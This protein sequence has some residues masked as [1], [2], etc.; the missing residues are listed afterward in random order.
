MGAERRRVMIAGLL[1]CVGLVAAGVSPVAAQETGDEVDVSTLYETETIDGNQQVRDIIRTENG[2]LIALVIT[3][4]GRETLV[5]GLDGSGAV[6][7]EETVPGRLESLTR[8][9][10]DAYAAAG[11]RGGTAILTR[12]NEDGWIEWTERY[13][14]DERDIGFDA[15]SAPHGDTYLLASTDSFENDTEYNSSNLWAVRVDDEGEIR[16]DRLIEYEQSAAF[17]QGERL[18][19]GSL[20][21]AIQTGRSV[22]GDDSDGESGVAA[23]RLAP[24]GDTEWRTTIPDIDEPSRSERV[25]DVAPAHDNGVVLAGGTNSGNADEDN[26]DAWAAQLGAD[27]DVVWQR[28]Y[29]SEGRT[30]VGSV[31]RTADGYLLAGGQLVSERGQT[32]SAGTLSRIDTDGTEQDTSI[33]RPDRNA[34]VIIRAAEWL[35]DGRLAIGGTNVIDGGGETRSEGWIDAAT[36]SPTGADPGPSTWNTQH[37]A[38]E[39]AGEGWTVEESSA[40]LVLLGATAVSVL[41]LFVPYGGRRLRRWR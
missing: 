39:Q 3:D 22:D 27:G 24:D 16:W 29:D 41:L 10:T 4:G 35:G 34:R 36:T 7:S 11:A 23:V 33:V 12:I 9:D 21:A 8:V 32:V 5:V 19:D 26:F 6:V 31:V 2:G 14:G 15:V 28:Q 20:V 17:P 13:G 30:F 38:A 40:D 18:A 37:S 1:L 25:T